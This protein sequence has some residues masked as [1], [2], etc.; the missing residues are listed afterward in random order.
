LLAQFANQGIC[1][2]GVSNQVYTDYGEDVLPE[3]IS[4]LIKV[5][6]TSFSSISTFPMTFPFTFIEDDQ[7]EDILSV[8]FPQ[9]IPE[10]KQYKSNRNDA[11]QLLAHKMSER[12]FFI[13]S[14]KEI[15]RAQ[16][17]LEEKFGIKV[18]SLSE[19]ISLKTK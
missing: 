2:L 17:I 11:L 12:E 3:N 16:L 10:H 1:E 19:Y 15:M 6:I 14:D 8:V 18:L 7:I 13:T 5:Y 9:S 4:K